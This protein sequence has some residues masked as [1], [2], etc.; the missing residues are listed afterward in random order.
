MSAEVGYYVSTTMWVEGLDLMLHAA[1]ETERCHD[2]SA[3]VHRP[4]EGR[5]HKEM[6]TMGARGGSRHVSGT[7]VVFIF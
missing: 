4:P 3:E 6:R 1:P 5:K 7:F 2:R